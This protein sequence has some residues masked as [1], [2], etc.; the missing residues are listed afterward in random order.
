MRIA[1]LRL[2]D[3]EP[4]KDSGI[5]TMD[6][7][8]TEDF[9]VIIGTN[10]SGKSQ[11]MRQLSLFPTV[12]SL[13]GKKGFRSTVIE[14]DGRYY[15]LESEYEKPS[16]PHL[17]FEGDDEENLNVGRTTDTQ[18]ELILEHLGITP[19]LDD[20]IMNRHVFPKWTASKRKEFLMAVNPDQIG[21]V[22]T[23]AKQ[24]AS[25]I[26]ACKNNIARLL[27]R[28]ILLEHELLDPDTIV[29]LTQEKQTINE[30][31]TAFQQNL[32]DLEVGL[33]T[34]GNPVVPSLTDL[35][36]ISE[37]VRRCRYRL[38]T[39]GHVSRDDHKRQSDRETLLSKIAVLDQKLEETDA[40]IINQ[41]S[42]LSELETRYRELSL[43][44][45]SVIS[46][47]AAERLEIDATI[48][49][50]EAERDKLQITRPPFEL[51][52]DELNTKYQEL[53]LVTDK[54]R[55]FSQLSVTLLSSKRRQHRERLLQS[56]QYKQGTWGMRLND[57]ESQYEEWVRR[58]T[59]S[60]ADIPNSPCAKNACPLYAQFMSDH[61]VASSK[62][63]SLMAAIEKGRRKIARL[64]KLVEGLIN[65]KQQSQPYVDQIQ[66]LVGYAQSNPILHHVLRQM[67]ILTVLS[68][69]PNRIIRQLQDA[70]D[71]IGQWLRL[72]TVS[73]DLEIA[74]G[75]KSRHISLQSPDVINLVSSIDKIKSSLYGL[76]DV[77]TRTIHQKERLSAELNDISTFSSIKDQLTN[78]QK[79][80]RLTSEALSQ[81]HERECLIY[82]RKGVE[83]LRGNNLQ[84]LGEIERTLRAQSSLQ[85]RYQ[86]EVLSQL[87]VIEKEL[88]D[89]QQI[90]KALAIIPKENMVGF[91]NSVFKQANRFIQ[92]VWTVPLKIELL[93]MDDPLNY[94]FI[95]SGDNASARELSECS[96]GQT[97]ILSLAINLAVRTVLGHLNFPLCLD[98]PGRTF[99]D[100]HKQNMV[101][102]LKSLVNDRIISQLFMI[103]H[104]ALI[105]E[106]L[107]H[108][109][110]LVIREDNVML[111]PKY[112][113]HATFR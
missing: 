71:Q 13:F 69:N 61:E 96:D 104:H 22:L 27:S 43:D 42:E 29:L 108:A 58:N 45:N 74:Y 88:A 30:E 6:V 65:H 66:W 18:K 109:E 47:G 31:L 26:K 79:W 28:K 99:D 16:S 7:T 83:E 44:Q 17:F 95:V 73:S 51:T 106:G 52:Q 68:T 54:L 15:R 102:L 75:V 38:V 49:R 35:P 67:D 19:L 110:T 101:N 10:G 93:T 100:R 5:S 103:S 90:E 23:L 78:I 2:D 97:E 81:G 60:P 84:R 57:L 8:F 89:L 36:S 4:Y 92:Q 24:N 59:M 55:I 37:T 107:S 50:L 63:A 21:F 25:K 40:E 20:L 46:D 32:M 9:Q 105:H 80:H 62:R 3:F 11:T 94:E 76:R 33:R 56:S 53:D 34:V 87:T 14:K 48:S 112:N 85:D 1:S 98:E 64:N 70:Y 41:S 82:L 86:E 12:R 77:I 72:K 91:I 113:E 111:P 39:L